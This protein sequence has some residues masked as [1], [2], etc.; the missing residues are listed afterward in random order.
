MKNYYYSIQRWEFKEMYLFLKEC[1]NRYKEPKIK[2]AN[3][4]IYWWIKS[5]KD[6]Y[7]PLN[8]I[9]EI[10][11][12]Y[13]ELKSEPKPEKNWKVLWVDSDTRIKIIERV[14]KL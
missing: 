10:A 14:L 9:G 11:Y 8:D 1:Q 2:V 12:K 4:M 6:L 3:N 5:N 7:R 13:K